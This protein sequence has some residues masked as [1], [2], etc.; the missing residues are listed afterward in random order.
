MSV[1]DISEPDVE[2][3]VAELIELDAPRQMIDD[4]RSGVILRVSIYDFDFSDDYVTF[5]ITPAMYS[6]I[7]HYPDGDTGTILGLLDRCSRV[8]DYSLAIET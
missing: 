1:S 4:A 8:L 6:L 5:D 7:G 3:M 2:G